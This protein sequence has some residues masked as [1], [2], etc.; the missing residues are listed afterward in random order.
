M[1]EKKTVNHAA[2]ATEGRI[3]WMAAWDA[4]WLA[5]DRAASDAAKRLASRSECRAAWAAVIM[6]ARELTLPPESNQTIRAAWDAAWD[7]AWGKAVEAGIV[8]LE[9]NGIEDSNPF[10]PGRFAWDAAWA[11][12]GNTA[13]VE[14]ASGSKGSAAWDSG[15]AAVMA[16]LEGS[17]TEWDLAPRPKWDREG[18]DRR[19]KAGKLAGAGAWNAA[20]RAEVSK[21]AV[22][23]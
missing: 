7:A 2:V 5:A 16:A 10:R 11:A 15:I 22:A 13:W 21:Q 19:A 6:A 1:E 9:K 18:R 3:A 23:L 8:V 20:Y 12:A 17:R 4:S 14:A